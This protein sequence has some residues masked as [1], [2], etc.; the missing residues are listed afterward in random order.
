MQDP[1]ALWTLASTIRTG[2]VDYYAAQSPAWP[3]PA[4]RKVVS[5]TP[6][7]DCELLAVQVRSAS[8][9]QGN[10]ATESVDSFEVGRAMRFATVAVYLFRCV[11][12]PDSRGN[13]PTVDE[14]EA[15]AQ[16]IY[17]DAVRLQ[18]ALLDMITDRLLPGCYDVAFEGWTNIDNQGGIG[19]GYLIARV[20]LAGW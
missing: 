14:E 18:N 2:I 20:N 19:G 13:G 11:A 1:T 5:G 3:M 6:A 10:V 15:A 16:P 7:M 12:T 4:V 9:H 8:H 17:Y